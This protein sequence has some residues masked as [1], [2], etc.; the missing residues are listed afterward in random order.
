MTQFE[1]FNYHHFFK[2]ISLHLNHLKFQL[3]A[4]YQSHPIT[5]VHPYTINNKNISISLHWH[6][7]IF[8]LYQYTS[9][10]QL[11][12]LNYYNDNTLKSMRYTHTTYN[13][14]AITFQSLRYTYTTLFR[15]SPNCA[16]KFLNQF[17]RNALKHQFKKRKNPNE[18]IPHTS[19]SPT[20]Y[21]RNT[22]NVLTPF[23]QH[24]GH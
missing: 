6:N 10:P 4:D 2:I 18:R 1:I 3:K 11:Q 22:P 5:L 8:W 15:Y 24:Q 13:L 16:L 7:L 21:I 14:Q 17:R 9:P 12:M 23:R 20:P 19:N